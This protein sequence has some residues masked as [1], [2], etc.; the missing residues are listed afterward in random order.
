[1]K[2]LALAAWAALSAGTAFA[3][4]SLVPHQHPHETSALPD[5]LALALAALLVGVG[6]V[7]LRRLRKE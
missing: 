4:T 7:A 2:T 5:V 3:H 1:M 6:V